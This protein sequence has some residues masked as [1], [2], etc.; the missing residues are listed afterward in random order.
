[1]F[2]VGFSYLINI[3]FHLH[4]DFWLDCNFIFFSSVYEGEKS[5]YKEEDIAIPV[6]VYGK[7][8][9]AAEQFIS[10][11]SSNYAILGSSIIY[12]PQTVSPVPKSLPVQV[13]VQYMEFVL[14]A[15]LEKVCFQ[16]LD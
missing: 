3:L 6:N 10:E 1:M 8:K 2:G 4:F 14:Y 7:T 15:L 9:V 16:H 13:N 11:K 5:F 12:G